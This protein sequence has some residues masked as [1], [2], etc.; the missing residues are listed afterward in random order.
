[1]T[2]NRPIAR[3]S[4]VGVV[5][6][7]GMVQGVALVTF[8]AASAIFTEPGRLRSLE[9]GLRRHVPAPGDHGDRS[10][11]LLGAGL[12][13]PSGNQA[14]LSLGPGGGPG[15]DGAALVSRFVMSEPCARSTRCFSSPPPAWA[16]A[17]A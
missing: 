15:L 10:S 14:H 4:E 6:A 8:P 12:D 3:R 9:H 5:Y 2:S 17:S 7:A 11:A 1:M 16:S 13:A